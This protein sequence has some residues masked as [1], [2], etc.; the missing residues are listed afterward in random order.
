M[1]PSGVDVFDLIRSDHETVRELFK[2]IE[3]TADDEV[4]ARA[5]LVREL[6]GELVSHAK[7]ERDVFYETLAERGE[8]R[9]LLLEAV[10][11]HEAIERALEDLEVCRAE[12]ERWPAKLAVLRDLVEHHHDHEE[13]EIFRMGRKALSR[14]EAIVLGGAMLERKEALV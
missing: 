12:D 3:A 8:D 14:D 4:R 9:A 11:E 5:E 6:A 13:R 1:S 2:R 10:E 7:A